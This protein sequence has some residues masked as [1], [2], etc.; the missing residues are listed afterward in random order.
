MSGELLRGQQQLRP[1]DVVREHQ[2]LG[3]VLL[4]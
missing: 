3:A 1:V 2:L 4:M